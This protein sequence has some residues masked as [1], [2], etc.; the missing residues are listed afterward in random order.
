MKRLE[1]ERIQG[2]NLARDSVHKKGHF[3]FSKGR[4]REAGTPLV[5]VQTSFTGRYT[6]SLTYIRTYTSILRCMY[7]H[8]RQCICSTAEP[9][10]D[11]VQ[12]A[13]R[14]YN[15]VESRQVLFSPIHGTS[16]HIQSTCVDSLTPQY[17]STTNTSTIRYITYIHQSKVYI[18]THGCKYGAPSVDEEDQP[19]Q[20]T[21]S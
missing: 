12:S 2:L 5:L 10:T 16:Q 19:L 15:I 1:N 6:H 7:R 9:H 8:Q 17:T 13:Y 20:S 4:E 3:Q 21:P 14:L 18:Y 11:R